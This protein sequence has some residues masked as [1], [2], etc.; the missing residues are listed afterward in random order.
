ML[1]KKR[2]SCGERQVKK[3][4]RETDKFDKFYTHIGLKF[5]MLNSR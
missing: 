4:I 1:K 5:K 2:N 3:E